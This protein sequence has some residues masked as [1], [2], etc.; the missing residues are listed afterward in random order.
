MPMF[1]LPTTAAGVR[2]RSRPSGGHPGA[3]LLTSSL[4][5][6]G[7]PG[8]PCAVG[9]ADRTS[10]GTLEP[11][12]S[13]EPRL[14][15]PSTAAQRELTGAE[16]NPLKS[17]VPVTTHILLVGIMLLFF[18]GATLITL[19]ASW[20]WWVLPAVIAIPVVVILAQRWDHRQKAKAARKAMEAE[21]R[22]ARQTGPAGR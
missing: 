18:L 10:R 5:V 6:P 14:N 4:A 13:S 7:G 16:L 15:R 17:N 2:R 8:R 19:Q 21:L 22:A 11:V 3:K 12:S 20:Q 9:V 1:P